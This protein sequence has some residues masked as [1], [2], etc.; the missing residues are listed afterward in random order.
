MIG[1]KETNILPVLA[2]PWFPPVKP[3]TVS[4]AGSAMTISTNWANRSCIAWKDVS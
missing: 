2:V 1:F 3:A 4:T